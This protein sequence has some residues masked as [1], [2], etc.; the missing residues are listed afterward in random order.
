MRISFEF[1]G[2]L[3][4]LKLCVFHLLKLIGM[5]VLL[6]GLCATSWL[7]K[8]EQTPLEEQITEESIGL[9]ARLDPKR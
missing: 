1:S 7:L 3:N 6:F 5:H 4:L 8:G 2:V 9:T